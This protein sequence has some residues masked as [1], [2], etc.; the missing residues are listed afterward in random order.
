MALTTA[1]CAISGADA[2][3]A[4][5]VYPQTS[6]LWSAVLWLRLSDLEVVVKCQAGDEKEDI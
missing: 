4:S 3:G 6:F 5:M 2:I 1:S